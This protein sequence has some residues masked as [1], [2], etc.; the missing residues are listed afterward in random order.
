M[1][2]AIVP[3]LAAK[4]LIPHLLIT[5]DDSALRSILRE[6]LCRR[7]FN[8]TEASDGLEAIEVLEHSDVHICLVDFHMPRLNGLEVIR[9]VQTR[10]Q[11]TPCVLMSA[12]LNEQIRAE[13]S[14]MRAYGVLAKPLRLSQ[15]SDLVCG[16][17]ADVYN[18]RP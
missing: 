12:D 5:D 8:V 11:P 1:L 7:G 4:M 10:L 15:V 6:G 2:A 9:H 14:A 17:L 18:W 13:A 16:A 3:A